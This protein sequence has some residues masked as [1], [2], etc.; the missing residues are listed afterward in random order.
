MGSVPVTLALS[1]RFDMKPSTSH[2]P[3]PG[4]SN[5]NPL[6]GLYVR[7]FLDPAFIIDDEVGF[8][9]FLSACPANRNPCSNDMCCRVVAVDRHPYHALYVCRHV[10]SDMRPPFVTQSAG[11]KKAQKE[12]RENQRKK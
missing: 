8:V 4:K 10:I 5:G 7:V 3:P 6:V 9:L 2:F 11:L 1:V 12:K